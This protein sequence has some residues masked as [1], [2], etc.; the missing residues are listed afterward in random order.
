MTPA[1][2]T[3]TRELRV[4]SR[5]SVLMES[6]EVAASAYALLQ[7]SFGSILSSSF[8]LLYSWLWYSQ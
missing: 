5:A 3:A 2:V 1:A 7:S 8:I 4:K 6:V